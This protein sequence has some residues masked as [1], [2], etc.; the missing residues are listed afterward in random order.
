MLMDNFKICYLKNKQLNI[1][2]KKAKKNMR[3]KNNKLNKILKKLKIDRINVIRKA[4][5]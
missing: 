2:L 1:Q 4:C 3:R 5:N